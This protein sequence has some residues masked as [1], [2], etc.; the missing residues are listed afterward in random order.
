MKKTVVT[1]AENII[2]IISILA[3]FALI[4]SFIKIVEE[5]NITTLIFIGSAGWLG[6][7]GIYTYFINK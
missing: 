3:F 7:V 4:F 2:K 6:L 1:I 5:W